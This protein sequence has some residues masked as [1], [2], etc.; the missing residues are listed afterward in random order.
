MGSRMRSRALTGRASASRRA[1][2]RGRAPGRGAGREVHAGAWRSSCGVHGRDEPATRPRCS[3]RSRG[4]QCRS[5]PLSNTSTLARRQLRSP[6]ADGGS[7][8]PGPQFVNHA[9]WSRRPS[10]CR[11]A[12]SRACPATTR[13]PGESRRLSQ[14]LAPGVVTSPRS[15]SRAAGW[16]AAASRPPGPGP[17]PPRSAPLPYV[18]C[19][20]R[21]LHHGQGDV[22]PVADEHDEARPARSRPA[23]RRGRCRQASCHPQRAVPSLSA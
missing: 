5:G 16:R 23:G 13:G 12:R 2:P 6:L 3:S 21:H 19:A 1:A 22:A 14:S 7:G 8:D 11:C 15:G 9:A 4:R 10:N 20:E 17:H 18:V